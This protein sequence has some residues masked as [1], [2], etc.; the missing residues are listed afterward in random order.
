NKGTASLT[1]NSPGIHKLGLRYTKAAQG[2]DNLEDMTS[3]TVTPHQ[4]KGSM[5]PRDHNVGTIADGSKKYLTLEIWDHGDLSKLSS[6]HMKLVD[7]NLTSDPQ[8]R[9]SS[10]IFGN[11][12]SYYTVEYRTY[13]AGKHHL[14]VTYD[15]IPI[16][17]STTSLIIADAN[18][19]PVEPANSSINDSVYHVGNGGT[20]KIGVKLIDKYGNGTNLKKVSLKIDD[21]NGLNQWNQTCKYVPIDEDGVYECEVFSKTVVGADERYNFDVMESGSVLDPER[22]YKLHGIITR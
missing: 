5:Y 17:M 4:Y 3:I 21:P 10:S 12:G 7:D 22:K 9:L 1:I 18:R 15:G 19:N 14:S 16:S 8:L 6:S 13:K 20:A 2:A 11:G